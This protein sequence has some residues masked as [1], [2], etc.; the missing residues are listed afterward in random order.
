VRIYCKDE[1][2]E[3]L[4]IFSKYWRIRLVKKGLKPL[5]RHEQNDGEKLFDVE[6]CMPI[7]ITSV[8]SYKKL[9][10]VKT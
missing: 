6:L 2:E 10:C 7:K 8:R 1:G 9:W 4:I 5:A 3:D